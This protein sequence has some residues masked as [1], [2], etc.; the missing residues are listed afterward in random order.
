MAN[1]ARSPKATSMMAR[2]KLRSDGSASRRAVVTT[3]AVV[4][5]YVTTEAPPP[6]TAAATS[7]AKSAA[8]PAAPGAPDTRRTYHS[9][10]ANPCVGWFAAG[11]E[12]EPLLVSNDG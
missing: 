6:A 4:S 10:V 9:A 3:I 8:M 11:D 5:A 1:A 12:Q 7:P 2:T